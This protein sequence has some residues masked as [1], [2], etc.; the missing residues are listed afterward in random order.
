MTSHA[1]KLIEITENNA[2]TI[3]E[4]WYNNIKMNPRTPS[5]HS[6]PEGEA[7]KQALFFFKNFGKL[8]FTDKPFEEAQAIF[9]KYAENRYKERIPLSEVIYA[10][11]LMRRHMWL[12]SSSQA[13]F[14]T[15][16]EHHQAAE[17]QSRTILM[18]DYAIFIVVQKYDELLKSEVEEKMK[19]LKIKSPLTFWK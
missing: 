18:F 9:S 10:L 6:L 11:T 19:A 7:K 16:V 12:Y 3:A 17:S 2:D 13:V 4:Q 5:Y 14:M 8:F 15:A 1:T